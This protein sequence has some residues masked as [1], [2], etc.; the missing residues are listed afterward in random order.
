LYVSK[1]DV[2]AVFYFAVLDFYSFVLD[3]KLTKD[4]Q[5]TNFHSA[6]V[7][8]L[9]TLR[10]GVA[11]YKA[12]P[13]VKEAGWVAEPVWTQFRGKILSLVPPGNE[14]LSPCRPARSQ[15]L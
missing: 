3:Y 12:V 15:A 6:F 8:S 4:I 13:I 11:I 10:R 2:N 7:I 1:V 9:S 5:K 14:S